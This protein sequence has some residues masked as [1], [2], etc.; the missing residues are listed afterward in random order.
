MAAIAP[1]SAH[2]ALRASC[3]RAADGSSATYESSATSRAKPA[4]RPLALPQR[5]ATEPSAQPA[6]ASAEPTVSRRASLAI[7]AC[8]SATTVVGAPRGAEWGT[9]GTSDSSRAVPDWFLP[10]SAIAAED[11]ASSSSQATSQQRIVRLRDVDDSELQAA[12]RAA[13]AGDLETAEEMFSR[14]IARLP[15]SA[16][17]WSNRGSVRMSL[18]RYEEAAEDFARAIE[19]APTA[20]VPL[21]NRGIALGALGRYREALKDC[22]A[23]VNVDPQEPAAWFNL[24]MVE[25]R[26]THYA[27]S[28]D[29][30]KKAALLA[31]GIAGYRMATAVVLVQ[32]G[33]TNQAEQIL[34]A[35]VRKYPNYAEAHA[36]LA[37]VSWQ[38]GETAEAEEQFSRGSALQPQLKNL[39]WVSDNYDWTPRLTESYRRFLAVD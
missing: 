14:L 34:K 26:L 7:L 22:Q 29:A 9:W 31:P 13:V 12:L 17:M 16:S 3:A 36:A 19:L 4:P 23:A 37:A 27:A 28:L 38:K 21:L 32:V 18:G 24:G 11:S 15:E 8:L 10:P 25:S 5:A 30:L 20:P 6:S 35:L 2:L 1:S 39:E 33:S